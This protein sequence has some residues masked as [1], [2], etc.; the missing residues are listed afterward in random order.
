MKIAFF[1]TKAYDREFFDRYVSTH[2]II[3]F[4][5]PL[6][7]HTVNL[8]AGCSAVCVFV[9]DRLDAGVLES[10]KEMSIQLIKVNK[11]ILLIINYREC[12]STSF[13]ISMDFVSQEHFCLI[14][15]SCNSGCPTHQTRKLS[16]I[17]QIAY[18]KAT[19][20]MKTL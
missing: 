6:N 4:E 9:N 8:A 15:S 13:I 16:V 12:S 14:I 11:K 5:A 1:S 10:L 3:Y 19:N 17:H 2:E 20:H 18:Q 7:K